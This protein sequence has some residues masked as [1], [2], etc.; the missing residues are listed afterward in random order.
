MKHL[1]TPLAPLLLAGCVAA[2]LRQADASLEARITQAE[3]AS[4][5]LV[6]DADA[7][8]Q[9]RIDAL[10][11]TTERLTAK[12]IGDFDA[13]LDRQRTETL[14][15]LAAERATILAAVKDEREAILA[16]FLA[17]S[18]AWRDESG[19]WRATVAP[20]TETVSALTKPPEPPKPGDPVSQELLWTAVA[21]TV[22]TVGKTGWRLW[23]TYRGSGRAS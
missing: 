13:R 11:E 3:A 20:L 10:A 23:R 16:A 21:G 9:K 5:T 1:L 8:L 14:A 7:R 17:E 19:K 12:A 15:A 6:S 18:A 4:R 2:P 22:F